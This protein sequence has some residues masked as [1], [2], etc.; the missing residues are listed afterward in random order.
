MQIHLSLD[1]AG[2]LGQRLYESLRRA[3]IDG[4]VPPGERLP[5]S[6]VLAAELG[7]SRRLVVE[8][9]ERLVAEGF[10]GGAPGRGTFVLRV[11]PPL[12]REAERPGPGPGAHWR[13]LPDWGGR[14]AGTTFPAASPT[15]RCCPG[16]PGAGP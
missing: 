2:G 15:G 8:A 10:L 5:S 4:Q 11:P 16:R 12:P 7:V 3:L 1:G 14:R 9:Y 13:P 6:R